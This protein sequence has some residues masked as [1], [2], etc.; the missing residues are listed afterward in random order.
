M[1]AVVAAVCMSHAPGML[2]WPD[3]PGSAVRERLKGVYARVSAEL[4]QASPD[5]I[6]AFL[7]DHFE[8]HYRNLMPTFS[9]GVAPENS[10]PPQYWL[11]AL[12]LGESRTVPSSAELAEGLLRH[13]VKSGFDVAR[14]G[15]C[16]YGNNLIVPMELLR[17]NYDIPVVPVFINTFT[18]P[19]PN[20]DRVFALGGAV[21]DYVEEYAG[22]R[23]VAFL[24]TG[25]LSHWPPFWSEDSPSDDALLQR[26]RTF[27]TEGRRALVSDPDL[28]SAL[29]RYEVD[30]AA[31][32]QW[33][34][35]NSHPL[36]NAEWDNTFMRAI[37]AGD[38]D[39]LC[40]LTY[41]D[42]DAKAGHGGHEIL[43]WVALAGAMRGAPAT[44]TFYEPV[45]EWI[46]G[47]GFAVF[48][49]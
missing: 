40:R 6:I 41:E 27:Q 38:V 39:Y 23:R 32:N 20:A 36:V 17:S 28:L 22:A 5:V 43:N 25:G 21:R 44:F 18:P 24:A 15:A 35:N 1:A 37:A 49:Q 48:R 42:V 47:I 3:A 45:V 30:M 4:A 46:C 34:L 31:A 9:V 7:D 10:G 13:F 33:P 11:A 29:A 14:M 19:I 8:N 16:E 12:G 2:G 26:M